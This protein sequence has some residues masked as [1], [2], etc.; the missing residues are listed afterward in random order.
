VRAAQGIAVAACVG[1]FLGS[2]GA[3]APREPPGA[4]VSVDQLPHPKPGLWRWTSRAGGTR[5]L[6]LSGQLLTVLAVR[7]GCPVVRQV[8]T[9]DGAFVV[10]AHCQDGPVKVTSVK[11]RGDYNT[12]FAADVSLGDVSDHADY[13]YLGACA[14]GQKPD[15][16]P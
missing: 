5:D 16:Q 3:D 15:D 2:C 11:V 10:E 1:A 8:R 4:A 9:T 6:C 13:L 14:A 7:P 12:A